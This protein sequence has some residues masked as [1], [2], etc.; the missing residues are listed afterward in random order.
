MA[1]ITSRMSGGALVVA[2]YGEARITYSGVRS[3]GVTQHHFENDLTDE[4]Q[5][6]AILSFVKL[7]Q[8]CARAPDK[9]YDTRERAP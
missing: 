3:G 8:V 2:E 7:T 5:C 6:V 9:Q 1:H 4:L